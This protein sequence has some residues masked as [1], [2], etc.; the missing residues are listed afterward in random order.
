MTFAMEIEIDFTKSAQENANDYYTKSKKLALKKEGA[1]KAIKEL[2][3]RLSE[4]SAKE[5]EAQPR[6][7]KAEKKEWYE[8]FHW[9]FTSS[10][11]LAIGGGDAHQN[12]MLN[13][14]HFE[15][16][17]LFFHAD[18]FGAPVVILK[19]GASAPRETREEVAQFAG[20][21]SSAWKEG[22]HN[23]DVY[24]MKRSQV[25]KSSSKG[26]L[27]T[28]SFLLSG[29]RDWYRSVQLVL[30]MFVK[31]DK[32]HTVP[33]ITFDK[34]GEEF[35]HVKVTQGNFK[36]SDA[37]KKIAAKLGYKD[38]DTIIRQLPAGSFRIE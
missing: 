34:L 32:L 21:Y 13:S 15:D 2:E 7:L 31:D 16:N 22:L 29:E 26:S 1:K 5:K 19:N 37:A 12:E 4:V 6:I 14:K 25:S 9:F 36:K 10:N 24:A 33:L 8:K 27:G 23:I 18:I 30:V 20:S 3:E 28:G 38:I 11:M 35:K 17:D